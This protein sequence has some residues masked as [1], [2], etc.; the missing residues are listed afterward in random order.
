MTDTA[1]LVLTAA[2]V[3][4]AAV[5][6]VYPKLRERAAREQ[7]PSTSDAVEVRGVAAD[8]FMREMARLGMFVDEAGLEYGV[9]PAA[10]AALGEHVMVPCHLPA[11]RAGRIEVVPVWEDAK[12]FDDE[13]LDTHR[14]LPESTASLGVTLPAPLLAAQRVWLVFEV[15]DSGDEVALVPPLALSLRNGVPAELNMRD[16]PEEEHGS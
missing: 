6:I 1:E 5:L 2:V 15:R 4:L 12:W 10:T 13:G 11:G 3:L 7:P 9:A 8:E 14:S 16:D